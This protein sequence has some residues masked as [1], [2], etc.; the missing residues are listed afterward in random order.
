MTTEEMI[1]TLDKN[2]ILKL[3]EAF[4]KANAERNLETE[5]AEVKAAYEEFKAIFEKVGL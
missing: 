3:K 2:G 5:S 4:D 1:K